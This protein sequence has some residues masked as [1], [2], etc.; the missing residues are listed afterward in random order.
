MNILTPREEEIVI[1]ICEGLTEPEIAERLSLSPK[2]V[3]NHN[4][5]I[6]MKLRSQGV[7]RKLGLVMWALE[8]GLYSLPASVRWYRN[9]NY[10]F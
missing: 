5:N 3:A 1:L 6:L 7:K 8:T 9:T 10:R 2:T 4:S